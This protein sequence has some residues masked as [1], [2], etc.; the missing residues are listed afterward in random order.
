MTLSVR[1]MGVPDTVVTI[2][3]FDNINMK[4]IIHCHWNSVKE[5]N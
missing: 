3:K 5:N 2:I 4:P 1:K